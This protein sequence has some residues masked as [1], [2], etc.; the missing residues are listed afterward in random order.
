MAG[1]Q[2]VGETKKGLFSCC[3]EMGSEVECLSNSTEYIR[4]R[5]EEIN[6][7]NS[8]GCRQIVGSELDDP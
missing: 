5:S 2:R 8:S 6:M 7:A 1:D 3:F 4:G